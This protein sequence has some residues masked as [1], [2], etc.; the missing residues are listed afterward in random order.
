[1]L[2]KE[3]RQSPNPIFQVFGCTCFALRPHVKRTKLSS[4]YAICVFLSYGESQKGY[5]RCFDL[6]T[7]KLYVSRHVVF[8][9]HI[10]FFSIP[11]ATHDLTRSDLIRI[12][13]FSEDFESFLSQ[14]PTTSNS[15][16]HV[17]PPFPLH[18]TQHVC[19]SSSAN[20]DTLLYRISDAPSSPMVPQVPLR[21]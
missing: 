4:R 14:V 2:E 19:D 15:P 17:L 21:L 11:F 12:D 10:P 16:S 20:I 18:Y 7:H 9:E 8:L 5:Y 6:D 3:T 13:P 1:M